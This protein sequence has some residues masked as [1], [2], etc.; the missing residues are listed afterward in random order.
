MNRKRIYLISILSIA[1]IS[2]IA[3]LHFSWEVKPLF[4]EGDY[5]NKAKEILEKG[6]FDGAFR[7]PLYPYFLAALI[8]VFNNNIYYV[9]LTQ[10]L[11]GTLS[12]LYIYKTAKEMFTSENVALIAAL[13]FCL[14]PDMVWYSCFLWSETLFLFLFLP[15]FYLLIKFQ[16]EN[17]KYLLFSAGLL[18]G[19]S[20]LTKSVVLYFLVFIL[21][22]IVHYNKKE[23][24]KLSVIFMT[25]AIIVISPWTIKNYV[26]FKR[27]IPIDTNGMFNLYEGNNKIKDYKIIFAG[28]AGK[29]MRERYQSFG[30]NE[31]E[32]E[33]GAL[34]EA[35]NYILEEQ[36]Q[37]VFK[38][39]YYEIPELWNPDSLAL[40]HIRIGRYGEIPP[41]LV[42]M[43]VL[44]FIMAYFF[45]IFTSVFGLINAPKVKQYWFVIGLLVYLNLIHVVTYASIR[46]N[47]FV[48]PFLMFYSAYTL[49]SLRSL[50]RES[51]IT[52]K[53]LGIFVSIVFVVLW[54][55]SSEWGFLINMLS[56]KI[57]A[58]Y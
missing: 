3:I 41:Y 29:E 6:Y 57:Y 54:A 22:W 19:L 23:G 45:V 7:P 2:R 10:V 4:D 44:Y 50:K 49:G 16:K 11:I 58:P 39:I 51:T 31:A 35:L 18:F 38:K 13:L 5:L 43:E 34:K 55:I 12:T 53:I 37:W 52:K 8:K 21:V 33:R 46:Y 9:K 17:N 30:N 48:L 32:R 56:G 24:L 1:L 36:P 20:A 42:V 26:E 28:P 40:R 14:Y 27:V 25:G 47:V 15:C